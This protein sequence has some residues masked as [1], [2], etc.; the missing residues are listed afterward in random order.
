MRLILLALTVIIV[1]SVPVYGM[2]TAPEP[3]EPGIGTGE[4]PLGV[5][6]PLRG[7]ILF[8]TPPQ[9]PPPPPPGQGPT[10]PGGGW[11]GGGAGPLRVPAPVNEIPTVETSHILRAYIV[12]FPDGTFRPDNEITR[13]EM[14]QMLYGLLDQP[15]RTFARSN[16][17]DVQGGEGW[18]YRAVSYLA[19]RG[20]IL[21][22][23][24]GTF[25][26][27]QPITR[28]EFTTLM[29]NFKQADKSGASSVFPDLAPGHWAYSFIMTAHGEGW[30]VGYPD[31]TFR[32]YGNLTRAEA[33]IVINNATTRYRFPHLVEGF[34]TFVDS[35]PN[36]WANTHKELAANDLDVTPYFDAFNSADNN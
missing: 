33:V 16:F 31:G 21:G 25:R 18:Y 12:G 9:P 5:S 36:H 35:N 3:G 10:P 17:S 8:P 32:P 11:G 15:T 22:Y 34:S 20:A 23:P 6:I 14:A 1:L 26:P 2:E 29:T 28:A 19:N 13:A 30:V 27:N 24:D 7:H 4:M